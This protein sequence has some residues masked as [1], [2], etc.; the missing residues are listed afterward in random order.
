MPRQAR[1][2]A[3]GVLHHVMGRGIERGRIFW[4]DW[5]KED[6]IRRLAELA[7]GKAWWVY[8]WALMPNHFHLLVR[9]GTGTLPRNMRTLM[10]GYAGYFNRRHNRQG[11]LFQNRYKS[12]VCEEERYFLEL[13]R[14]LH[15]NPV[16][17]K[18][19]TD[20]KELDGYKY[21]GHSAIVGKSEQPWQDTEGVLGRF[22]RRRTMAIRLYR[23]FMEAGVS[24]GRRPELVGGGL[25]RSCGGWKGVRDL[26]RG[27]EQYRADE[28][29]LGSSSFVEGILKE[30]ETQEGKKNKRVSLDTLMGRITEDMGIS[31]EA[32]AGGG[33]NRKVTGARAALAY[34]WVRH[35]GRSGHELA[36]AL[37]VSSQSVYA[38]SNRAVESHLIELED[39]DRWCR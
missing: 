36:K 23:E 13:V 8:A 17:A 26:R 9:S 32:M 25:L 16:R 24:Q 39:V 7:S 12:T 38:A 11:H 20:I 19:V 22:S 15:L 30:V 37:D 14:Y 29:V 3:P 21:S 6:F 28:R 4:D 27:R 35:L 33:R 18:I 5:D 10:S 34:V 31:R 2:D 1:L